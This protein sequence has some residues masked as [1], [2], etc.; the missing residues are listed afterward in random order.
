MNI[1]FYKYHGCGNDFILIDNREKLLPRNFN[2][3]I[4]SLC[5]RRFGIG[6]DGLMLL[7]YKKKFDFEMI[8]YNADGGIGSMCGNGGRCITAFAQFLKI[9]SSI[10]NKYEF[11]AADGKHSASILHDK[12]ISLK[13]NEVALVK[14]NKTQDYILNTGSPH[15]VRF[16]KDLDGMNVVEEGRKIRNSSTFKKEG[17]N[18]NFMQMQKNKITLRTYERGVE[19]ETYSCGTGVTAAAIVYCLQNDFLTE[20]M[21]ISIQ[22]LGGD[23]KVDLSY[24]GEKFHSIYLIGNAVQVF[25]GEFKI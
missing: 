4:A 17:I 12:M 18:V 2:N 9:P 5:D 21:Q 19:D 7:Q 3:Q 23:F 20:N 13:M 6:A 8:Y 10:K 14:K 24:D 22:T 11:L 15:F 1:E 25:R 16:V